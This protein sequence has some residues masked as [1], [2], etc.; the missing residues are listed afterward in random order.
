MGTSRAVANVLIFD[1]G[2]ID[3][4]SI[5]QCNFSFG[6]GANNCFINASPGGSARVAQWSTDGFNITALG[7][8]HNTGP[9][10]FYVNL[11]ALNPPT[12][13]FNSMLQSIET[14]VHTTL[15]NNLDGVTAMAVFQDPPNNVLVTDPSG[16]RT[17]MLADGTLVNEIPGSIYIQNSARNA[18]LVVEPQPGVSTPRLLA[19]QTARL[20]CRCHLPNCC[21]TFLFLQSLSQ[22]S[23]GPYPRPE[24]FFR[25]RCRLQGQEDLAGRFA[26]I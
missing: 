5:P 6:S 9:L 21:P 22:T 15:I 24:V 11:D 8:P 26:R 19:R 3:A 18:V 2:G 25:L 1:N 23:Q 4:S 12:G 20:P 17:G 10:T 16:L 13:D 14:F 7:I